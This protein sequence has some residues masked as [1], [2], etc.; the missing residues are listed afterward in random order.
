[1]VFDGVRLSPCSDPLESLTESAGILESLSV[2]LFTSLLTSVRINLG[3][4]W[5]PYEEL[6]G[7]LSRIVVN[8]FGI[9]RNLF[10]FEPSDL[11]EFSLG[12]VKISDGTCWNPL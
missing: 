6:C 2:S 9:R 1:M 11:V 5:D 3:I 7:S 12:F 4:H 8:P 10:P